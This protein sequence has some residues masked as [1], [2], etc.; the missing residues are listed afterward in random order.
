MA[1]DFYVKIDGIDGDS[2]DKSHGK[3]IEV[4]SFSHGAVQNVG[5]GRATDVSGRGAFEPFSF[6]HLIDKAT[7][8]IQQFCMSGQ[9][10]AKVQFQVC[11]AMAGKQEP[12]YEVTMENVKISKASIKSVVS[13]SNGAS[14]MIDSFQG[15]D[16]A[17]MPLEQVE[18]IAG[19]ITWKYT[20]IKPDNTKDGAVE[21]TFNQV[22]NA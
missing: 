12:V 4:V 5:A 19:K 7:P 20:A 2:N 18:L 17:Y 15:A 21:A 11:R 9:K 6:V 1:S 10:V 16:G 3:W 14:S 13:G 8:K 22:E